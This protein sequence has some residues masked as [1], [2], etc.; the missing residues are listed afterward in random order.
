M[1]LRPD[2]DEFPY[3]IILPLRAAI[4]KNPLKTSSSPFM[5]IIFVRKLQSGSFAYD[6]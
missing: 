1:I 4:R 6:Y 2:S 3:I 5:L